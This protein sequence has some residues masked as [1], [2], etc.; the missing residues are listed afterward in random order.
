LI[1]NQGSIWRL[2]AFSFV[3]FLFELFLFELFLFVLRILG[4]KGDE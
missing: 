3:L 1:A 2:G 4:E